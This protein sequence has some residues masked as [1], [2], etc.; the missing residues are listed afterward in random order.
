M[1]KREEALNAIHRPKDG[2]APQAP[3][4]VVPESDTEEIGYAAGGLRNEQGN[5]ANITVPVKIKDSNPKIKQL[6][7]NPD[8]IAM[9]RII[10]EQQPP[11]SREVRIKPKP[12]ERVVA[13][14][15]KMSTKG[16]LY[17][18]WGIYT[19]G[20]NH[21]YARHAG[22]SAWKYRRVTELCF[23]YYLN[24]LRSRNKAYLL[25]AEREV[26]NV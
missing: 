17:D 19:E 20:Q 12:R 1:S 2:D 16:E 8:C 26:R 15:I 14:Y 7:D 5:M 11:R 13:Y 18:P 25:N 9:K 4:F 22:Q 6:V 3:G 21:K 24:F 10:H 23:K